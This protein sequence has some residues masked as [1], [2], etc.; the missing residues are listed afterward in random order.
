VMSPVSIDLWYT[1]MKRLA[2][3]QTVF[4]DHFAKSLG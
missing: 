2:G 4:F 1:E 3:D